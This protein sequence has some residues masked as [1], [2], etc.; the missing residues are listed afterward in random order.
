M[1]GGFLGLRPDFSIATRNELVTIDAS[2]CPEARQ[3][4][5]I[6]GKGQPRDKSFYVS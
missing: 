6:I 3:F 2:N 1:V 5:G 4:Y